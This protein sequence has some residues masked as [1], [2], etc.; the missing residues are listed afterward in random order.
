MWNHSNRIQT[1]ILVEVYIW[2]QI[3][4]LIVRCNFQRN[5]IFYN[6]RKVKG[7]LVSS[8]QRDLTARVFKLEDLRI[9]KIFNE[10]KLKPKYLI[11]KMHNFLSIIKKYSFKN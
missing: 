5:Q 7:K 2:K 6:Y 10:N 3:Q 1:R 9:M 11:K 8:S 4:T